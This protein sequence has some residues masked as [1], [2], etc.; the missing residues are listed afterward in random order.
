VSSLSGRSSYIPGIFLHHDKYLG[1]GIFCLRQY[2][3]LWPEL[4]IR[5]L[6]PVNSDEAAD[7]VR[8]EASEKLDI[9]IIST[10]P[11]M[12]ATLSALEAAAGDAEWAFWCSSDRYPTLA[13]ADAL[14]SVARAITDPS[15]KDLLSSFQAIRVVHWRDIGDAHAGVAPIVLGG[16]TF[17]SVPLTRI[18]FWHPQ[19]M[20]LTFL[21][22]FFSQIAEDATPPSLQNILLEMCN[23]SAFNAASCTLPLM[24]VEE[25]VRSGLAT[26]NF[27]AR[28]SRANGDIDGLELDSASVAFSCVSARPANIF[29]EKA[30]I[31][32][33]NV[34]HR[35]LAGEGPLHVVSAGGVGSKQIVTWLMGDLPAEVR[36]RAHSHRRIPPVSLRSGERC[37]YVFGDP[38]NAVLSIF[39]R[40]QRRH[41]GHGFEVVNP[42]R[43]NP[44]PGFAMLH[45]RN[46]ESDPGEMTADW[47][48]AKYLEK[49]YD[50]F[51][52][53]EHFDF[54]LSAE[55]PYEVVFV[56]YETLWL[57]AE[58]LGAYLGVSA[59]PPTFRTRTSDW[60]SLDDV[61]R[62]RMDKLHG[63]FARRLEAL[64][65]IFRIRDG[66]ASL[67]DE[68]P[69]A[70]AQI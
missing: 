55:T 49:Q 18:G 70:F 33:R 61:Q 62:P 35:P 48:L 54:W 59:T 7:R 69:V 64:P 23:N 16:E 1:A 53:E 44:A 25:P 9:E 29:W 50:A 8:R 58:A 32:P 60:R 41:Q 26:I 39:N 57:H 19:F 10:P 31:D 42:V 4:P 15:S 28:Q 45:A 21:R 20:R 67:L 3:R 11:S 14:N 43:D 36:S 63:P 46:L 52:L 30:G 12:R 27:V 34:V 5:F 37:I 56:R 13:A 47:D 40:R 22:K 6:V 24:K 51:R 65:D 17:R 66:K 38:R 2:A 68:T